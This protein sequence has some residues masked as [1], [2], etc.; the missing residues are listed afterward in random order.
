VVTEGQVPY[1]SLA[2]RALEQP[3]EQAGVDAHGLT[4]S[5]HLKGE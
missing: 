2:E 1:D 5:E 3:G 4:D